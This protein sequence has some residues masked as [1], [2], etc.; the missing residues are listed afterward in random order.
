MK[1]DPGRSGT[2]DRLHFHGHRHRTGR[3]EHDFEF[4]VGRITGVAFQRDAII[5]FE[6]G[7]RGCSDQAGVRRTV[8]QAVIDDELRDVVARNVG[9]DGR[10]LVQRVE[11]ARSTTG[12]RRQRPEECQGIAV[13]IRRAAAV[14]G[15]RVADIDRL[16][17]A[18]IGNRRRVQ[19]RYRDRIGRAVNE[20]VVDDELRDIIAGYVHYEARGQRQGAGKGAGAARGRRQGPGEGNRITVHVERA[21]AVEG[22]R[23]EHENR[24][25]GTGV[26]D[27]GRIQGRHCRGVGR[28]VDEAVVDDELYDVIARRVD[29]EGR[30]HDGRVGQRRGA[31]GRG[32]QRPGEG[33]RIAIDV[34]RCGT[35]ERHCIADAARLVG[36]GVGDRGRIQGRYGYRIGQAVDQAVVDDELHEVIASRVDDEGR[37]HDG[38]VGQRRGAAG[39]GR[40]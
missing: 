32:R 16:V 29:N 11:R 15:Y 23:I 7:Q 3:R 17:G 9:H 38:R 14:E 8:D 13:D 37:R 18:S 27:R 33:Q 28:A 36:A 25:I 21:A 26:G 34:K 30:R 10:R 31:A 2:R 19:R 24:L 22:Y 35:V 1:V 5:Y 6:R 39:R 20:A 40:Q 12:G 4:H